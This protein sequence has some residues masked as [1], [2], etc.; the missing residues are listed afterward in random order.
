MTRP[1]LVW[2]A[3][4]IAALYTGNTIAAPCTGIPEGSDD[5][6]ATEYQSLGRSSDSTFWHT[7]TTQANSGVYVWKSGNTWSLAYTFYDPQ[8]NLRVPTDGDYVETYSANGINVQAPDAS[9]C[10]PVELPTVRV[11]APFSGGWSQ[12][13][14]VTNRQPTS[15]GQGS[16]GFTS[17]AR[18]P[19]V[20][21]GSRNAD[22]SLT[23]GNSDDVTRMLAARE[24]IAT[25]TSPF[26]R[27]GI[28]TINYQTGTSQRWL[29]TEPFATT[30]GLVPAGECS[31]P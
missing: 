30:L 26:N 15:P 21:R 5:P 29:V 14:V 1:C 6:Q 22:D 9:I 13:V 2:P 23:C 24:A 31:G 10:N 11:I 16:G 25:S 28:Y 19:S 7:S 12:Y 18:K 8:A 20:F 3:F 27:R 17:I 4:A